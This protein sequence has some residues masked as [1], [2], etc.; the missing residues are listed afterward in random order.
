MALFCVFPPANS[1]SFRAHCVKVHV[2]YLI[3]WWVLVVFSFF[4]T[5]FCLVLCG[6][7]SWLLVSFL[8]HVNIVYGIISYRSLFICRA[9]V[10]R[11]TTVRCTRWNLWM[12]TWSLSHAKFPADWWRRWA[13]RIQNLAKNCGFLSSKDEIISYTDQELNLAEKSTS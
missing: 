1:G 10:T 7:L 3:S 4:I 8:A 13:S 5:L 9:G 11:C 12:S 6:R 2:R